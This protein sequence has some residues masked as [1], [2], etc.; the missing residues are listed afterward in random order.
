MIKTII[1]LTI[2]VNRSHDVFHIK[3]QL[4]IC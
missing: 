4:L 1:V 2:F 3:E